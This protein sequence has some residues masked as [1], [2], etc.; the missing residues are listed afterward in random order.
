LKMRVSEI[1]VKRICVNQGLGVPRYFLDTA[2]PHFCSWNNLRHA[3]C[4][5]IE[6]NSYMELYILGLFYKIRLSTKAV[7]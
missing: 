3:K 4:V 1:C 2:I 5:L 7:Q 6:T